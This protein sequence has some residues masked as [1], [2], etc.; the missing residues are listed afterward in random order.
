MILETW[1]VKEAKLRSLAIM[2]FIMLVLLWNIYSHSFNRTDC[3]LKKLRRGIFGEEISNCT[4]LRIIFQ[5]ILS[6]FFSAAVAIFRG[7]THN[8]FFCNANLYRATGTPDR[9]RINAKYVNAL[10]LEANSSS[11]GGVISSDSVEMDVMF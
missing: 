2:A 8:L 5:S 4:I 11:K 9:Q 6:L 10:K 1:I 3:E 7:Q